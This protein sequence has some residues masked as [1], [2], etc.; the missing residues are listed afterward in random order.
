MKSKIFTFAAVLLLVLA[1]SAQDADVLG[2][3][4]AKTPYR[5][6][7]SETVFSQAKSQIIFSR[8]VGETVFSFMPNGTRLIGTVSFPEGKAAISEGKIMGDK[9]S[10]VVAGDPSAN[11]MTMG[12]KGKIGLNEIK[13]T[14][15]AKDGSGQPLE[16]TARREFLRH[17]D[18]IPQPVPL[19]R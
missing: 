10:F 2:N 6:A 3:W 7:M 14:R 16:F 15:T 12:Y 8:A 9:I 19:P 1:A 13:F 4:I 11:G 18:Y 5:P 17:N